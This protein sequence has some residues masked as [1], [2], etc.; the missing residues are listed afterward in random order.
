M[1]LIISDV[2]NR[3]KTF[4]LSLASTTTF[5]LLIQLPV[6]IRKAEQCVGIPGL[7]HVYGFGELFLSFIS[8]K[9]TYTNIMEP[10]CVQR[11]GMNGPVDGPDVRPEYVVKTQYDSCILY[12]EVITSCLHCSVQHFFS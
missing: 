9:R 6:L 8:L 1:F 5:Q 3:K 2:V 12:E 7:Y 4:V 11:E 10:S